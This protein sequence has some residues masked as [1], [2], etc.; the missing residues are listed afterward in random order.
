MVNKLFS[1]LFISLFSLSLHASNGRDTIADLNSF[2]GG[3]TGVKKSEMGFPEGFEMSET[4]VITVDTA[5]EK[6]VYFFE[7][8]AL[9]PDESHFI[10]NVK[11]DKLSNPTKIIVNADKIDMAT[12]LRKDGMIWVVVLVSLVVFAGLISYLVI[13]DRKVS[14]LEKAA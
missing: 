9:T 12:G 11:Y 4:G 13:L 2:L 1:C 6:G 8:M 7:L 14:K 5:I 10:V 3:V